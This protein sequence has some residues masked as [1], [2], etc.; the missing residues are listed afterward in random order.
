MLPFLLVSFGYIISLQSFVLS[1]TN[2]KGLSNI[3]QVGRNNATFRTV[4]RESFHIRRSNCILSDQLL[5]TVSSSPSSSSFQKIY[6][7]FF[8]RF[9]PLIGGPNIPLHVEVMMLKSITPCSRISDYD[10][11]SD[12]TKNID[13]TGNMQCLHR[14]D[15]IPLEPT[16]KSTIQK[17]I[18]LQ[19]V[20]GRLRHRILINEDMEDVSKNS[21]IVTS[22]DDC[23]QIIV[24]NERLCELT[25]NYNCKN[26]DE[27]SSSSIVFQI[28]N[29]SN[30]VMI[31][32]K[33][34]DDNDFVH[35]LVQIPPE[36][37]KLFHEKK[38]VE[39]N[40]LFYNCYSFAW[41]VLQSFKLVP[42]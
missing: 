15:F 28:S 23:N 3:Q 16:K 35:D 21:R 5:T 37:Q 38:D 7:Q 17:L 40:L 8:V 18:T 26:S 31:S 27:S 42:Q 41:N 30:R 32:S 29:S 22:N 10:N 2:L 39:L 4:G 36:I 34:Y 19:S 14:F 1:Y 11:D 6:T 9:S 13:K 12:E 24:S 25:R 33:N 20:P